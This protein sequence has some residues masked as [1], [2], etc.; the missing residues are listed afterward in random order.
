MNVTFPFLSCKKGQI[1]TIIPLSRNI[2]NI[3]GSSDQYSW[4]FPNFKAPFHYS[5]R[6]TDIYHR[7]KHEVFHSGFGHIY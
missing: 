4:D 1:C 3:S 5:P 7:T 2:S 6:T